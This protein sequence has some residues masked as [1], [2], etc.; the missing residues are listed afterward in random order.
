MKKYRYFIFIILIIFVGCHSVVGKES[1]DN[2]NSNNFGSRIVKKAKKYLGTPYQYGGTGK[3]G[4][5]CSGLVMTVFANLGVKLPRMVKDQI[6]YGKGIKR[7]SEKAGDLIFFATRKFGK[8]GHVGIVI[9]NGKMIHSNST[10][11]SVRITKYIGNSYW[12]SHFKTIR[13]IKG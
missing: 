13:R 9:G 2:N 1:Y 4:F 7:G 12:E 6:K 5:D 3:P 8:V 11:G 10:G